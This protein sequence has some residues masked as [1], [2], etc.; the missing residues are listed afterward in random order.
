MSLN[1]IPVNVLDRPTGM[2]TALLTELKDHLHKLAEAGET[3][4][5]DLLSLPMTEADINELADHLG[6]GEVK[7]T[8][9]SI[10]SSSIR[11]TAY[12]GIWWITHY[13]DD[14]KVL[15]ELIEITQVPEI[16]VTHMDEIRHSAGAIETL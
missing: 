3:N 14:G 8:I 11:E 16:L 7:A 4:S 6:V 12:R 10:G 1:D 2:A 9:N 15:S 13:G 5:I